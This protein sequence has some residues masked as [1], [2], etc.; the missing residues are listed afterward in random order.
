MDD[1]VQIVNCV[2]SAQSDTAEF[3]DEFDQKLSDTIDFKFG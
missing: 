2:A 1:T 3:G